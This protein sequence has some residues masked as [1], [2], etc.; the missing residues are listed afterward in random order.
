[1]KL[2]SGQP[3]APKATTG[4]KGKRGKKICPQCDEYV[5]IHSQRCWNCTFTFK[6]NHKPKKEK[7][8][9]L[10]ETTYCFDRVSYYR[11]PGEGR[12]GEQLSLILAKNKFYGLAK[13]AADAPKD[14]SNR[15]TQR[16][17]KQD[18]ESSEDEISAQL[19]TSA[20]TKQVQMANQLMA[21]RSLRGEFY[22]LTN[23]RA[24]AEYLKPAHRSFS[25]P[26]DSAAL[27]FQ[28]DVDG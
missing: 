19:E 18:S 21:R 13:P 24:V 25:L 26:A 23:L 17:G 11:L 9:F 12:S 1:M 2:I 8:P 14:A 15:R 20:V 4:K 16:G 7:I 22:D 28:V 3:E 27:T 10:G 5:P 6:M